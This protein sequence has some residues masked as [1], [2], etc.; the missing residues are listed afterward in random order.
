MWSLG[1]RAAVLEQIDRS[2]NLSLNPLS[3]ELGALL[4]PGSHI[5]TAP[6]RRMRRMIA[7]ICIQHLHFPGGFAPSG[8]PGPLQCQVSVVATSS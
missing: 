2:S 5:C 8:L 6:L 1:T 4:I 7:L 3:E